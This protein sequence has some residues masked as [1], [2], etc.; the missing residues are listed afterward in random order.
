MSR[1]T[2]TGR[3]TK[4]A[5][6]PERET[7]SSAS[8][9]DAG[10]VA[11]LTTRQRRILDVIRSA[12][13]ERGYPPTVREI[14][15]SVGLASTSSV[16]HQLTVLQEKGYLRRDPH[17]PRALLVTDTPGAAEPA[18]RTDLHAE[19][20][21]ALV[22]LLGRI[23]AGGP[24][25]AEEQVESV[26]PLPRDLVGQGQLFVLT[27]VG[28]SMIEAAIC[29]GDLVVIRSQPTAEPGEIVAALIGDEAT[30][31]TFSRT[32]GHVWLLPQNPA[33][34]PIPGDDA[35]ILGRV[36]SVMRRL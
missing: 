25:L 8:K 12:V 13:D 23:A 22:P 20:D 33:Y 3:T 24:I 29:D 2:T 18:A 6:Q 27:V 36:V 30:V 32:D 15:E 11:H 19:G 17:R 14:C 5:R 4:K 7:A 31:K 16:A 10:P 21:L 9:D 1:D 28:D 35:R 26:L 34:Q